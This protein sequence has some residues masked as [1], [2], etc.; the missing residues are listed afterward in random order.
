MAKN[1]K[2]KELG[3]GIGQRKDGLY[4]ARCV[5]WIGERLERCFPHW[6][7]RETGKKSKTI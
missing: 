4:Y 3:K 5:S 1:L 7:M 6:W 2:G